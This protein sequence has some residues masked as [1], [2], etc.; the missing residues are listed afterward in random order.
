MKPL[1]GLYFNPPTTLWPECLLQRNKSGAGL[2]AKEFTGE[3]FI[4]L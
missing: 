2:L 4:S 1:T 3:L